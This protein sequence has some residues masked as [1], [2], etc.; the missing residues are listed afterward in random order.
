MIDQSAKQMINLACKLLKEIFVPKTYEAQFLYLFPAILI[1]TLA[2]F[3]FL[4][5]FAAAFSAE[6]VLSFERIGVIP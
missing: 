4:L 5:L 3:V 6:T 1:L 2:L